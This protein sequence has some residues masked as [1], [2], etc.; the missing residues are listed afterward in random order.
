VAAT[1]VTLGHDVKE[2]RF[3]IVIESLVIEEELGEKAEVLTVDLVFLAVDFE[4]GQRPIAVDL[5]ARGEAEIT[6]ELVT[7]ESLLFLHVLETEL[8]DEELI[9]LGKLLWVRRKVPS[10][11]FVAAHF[12][13]IDV[14]DFGDLLM[15]LL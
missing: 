15:F 8:A 13:G 1:C 14:L 5:I 6:L 2:E 7:F 11:H 3:Y 4:H 12:D 10:I 9:T